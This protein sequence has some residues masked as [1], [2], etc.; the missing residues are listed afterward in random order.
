MLK[1]LRAFLKEF[2]TSFRTTGA[3]IPSSRY[4]A[5]EMTSRLAERPPA[6]IRVLE[7]GPATGAFTRKILTYLGPEDQLDLC[8]INPRFVQYLERWLAKPAAGPRIRIFA[9]SVLEVPVE[10]PYDYIISGLPLNNFGP[11]EVQA[12]L[13]HF[14]ALGRP[15][16]EFSDFEYWSLR[17]LMT[18]LSAGAE[19]ARLKDV[20]LVIRR[21][22]RE[23]GS[24]KS[25]VW[26]NLPPARAL[27][28]RFQNGAREDAANKVGFRRPAPTALP[29]G[30]RHF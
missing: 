11:L 23:H 5:T 17:A 3:V 21:F 4:L 8:E 10:A 30:R 7:A 2:R 20:N 14:L 19:R 15:G 28:F 6:P 22:I 18:G 16:T 13:E 9:R 29:P 25:I 1:D 12:I 26:R 24:E 27:H